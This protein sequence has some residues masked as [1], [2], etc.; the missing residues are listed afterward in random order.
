MAA[1][2]N[3]HSIYG[4]AKLAGEKIAS[5]YGAWSIRPGFIYGGEHEGGLARTLRKVATT[6]P[7]IPTIGWGDQILHTVHID[8]LNNILMAIAESTS[9]PSI[10]PVTVACRTP[11]PFKK[12]LTAFANTRNKTPLFIPIPPLAIFLPLKLLE[13][14]GLKLPVRSDSLVSLLATNPSPDFELPAGIHCSIR[15][16]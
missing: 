5:L 2:T 9:T 6:L 12:I 13:K 1:F 4:N 14:L 11:Y 3:C 8:D 16:L 7:V 10:A 15:T